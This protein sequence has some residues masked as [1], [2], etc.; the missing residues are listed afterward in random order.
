MTREKAIEQ[1][2]NL[3]YHCKELLKSSKS[4]VWEND[5]EA[6]EMAIKILSCEKYACLYVSEAKKI[7]NNIRQLMEK[8]I[9]ECG[10]VLTAVE[11]IEETWQIVEE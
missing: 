1:L 11:G 2:E 9:K 10:I 6:L 7:N 8:T 4:E 5:V 3:Q